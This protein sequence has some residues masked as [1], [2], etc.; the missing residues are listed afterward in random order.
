MTNFYSCL[1]EYQK[2]GRNLIKDEGFY[3]PPHLAMPTVSKADKKMSDF[4]KGEY[5]KTEE[6]STY[7]NFEYQAILRPI[8]LSPN[9][10]KKRVRTILHA[11]N[12]NATVSVKTEGENLHLTILVK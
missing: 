9:E 1:K 4:F 5:T 2:N 6:I 11:D 8:G 7:K 10:I 12:I 3:L